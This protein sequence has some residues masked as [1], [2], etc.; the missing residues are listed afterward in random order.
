MSLIATLPHFNLAIC[1]FGAGDSLPFNAVNNNAFSGGASG[2]GSVMNKS[3]GNSIYNGLQVNLVKRFGHGIQ[4]QGAYT[5][6]HAISNVNDPLNAASGNRSFP[7][8]SFDLQA[9]RG[10]SDFDIRHRGVVNFIYEPSVGRGHDHLSSGI[11]GRILEGWSIN[12]LIQAQTGHPYDIF[13]NQD[14]NHTGLSARGTFLGGGSQ[15]AGTDKTFTGPARSAFE[16]TPFDV[17][18]NIGK[19]A[20]YGPNYVNVDTAVL[21]NTSVTERMKLQMRVEVFNLFNHAQFSQPDNLLQD[22][23]FGQSQSTITRPDGTTSA[24]QIQVALKLLF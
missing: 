19:N 9:E 24:R 23:T 17:Q 15:P 16:I 6:S 12:G 1:G 20:W 13:G 3:I 8:N 11:L 4:F 22:D 7:R 18:P 10:N 21:K 5:Y 2:T 14:S